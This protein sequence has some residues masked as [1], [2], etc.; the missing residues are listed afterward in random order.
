MMELEKYLSG[1]ETRVETLL[2]K[3]GNSPLDYDGQTVDM[4]D[5]GL[6]AAAS[7]RFGS[8]VLEASALV[9]SDARSGTFGI[10]AKTHRRLSAANKTSRFQKA[11]NAAKNKWS[12]FSLKVDKATAQSEVAPDDAEK[13]A[14]S[15]TTEG[16]A[17]VLPEGGPS[18]AQGSVKEEREQAVEDGQNK[19]AQSSVQDDHDI[20]QRLSGCDFDE[21]DEKFFDSIPML[22]ALNRPFVMRGLAH[23]HKWGARVA[24]KLGRAAI[25]KQFGELEVYADHIPYKKLFDGTM[26]E[27]EH[28]WD[29]VDQALAQHRISMQEYVAGWE[30]NTARL[31]TDDVPKYFFMPEKAL[32]KQ[33]KPFVSWWAKLLGAEVQDVQPYLGPAFSGAPFHWHQTAVN[34]LAHGKKLWLITQPQDTHYGAAASKTVVKQMLGDIIADAGPIGV[35]RCVQEAGDVLFVPADYGHATLN[36]QPSAGVAFEFESCD[37]SAFRFCMR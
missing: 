4:D 1:S 11:I 28:K 33:T 8:A 35:Q 37:W 21:Y 3:H 12:D 31:D 17:S 32:D 34:F 20:I 18:A 13:G 9:E 14:P 6:M 25:L 15:A 27:S 30:N 2:D 10:Q 19:A 26:L 7:R 36:L 22:V 5:P 16:D 23:A 24:K 29:S